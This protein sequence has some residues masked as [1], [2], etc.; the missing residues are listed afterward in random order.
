MDQSRSPQELLADLA[1]QQD[2]VCLDHALRRKSIKMNGLTATEVD[3]AAD[4]RRE[5]RDRCLQ[6]RGRDV[7]YGMSVVEDPVVSTDLEEGGECNASGHMH[8]KAPT[9]NTDEVSSS[10]GG[11]S[12]EEEYRG[13][14]RRK[15]FDLNDLLNKSEEAGWI[16]KAPADVEDSLKQWMSDA[17]W[18]H[19]EADE[20]VNKP[21]DFASQ[22]VTDFNN[23][24]TALPRISGSS[25]SP[26]QDEQST[27]P[28]QP[29]PPAIPLH[30]HQQARLDHFLD[31]CIW[32]VDDMIA[33]AEFAL[34]SRPT[35]EEVEMYIEPLDADGDD[36]PAEE[37]D[38]AL[39]QDAL[40]RDIDGLL[41]GGC[42]LGLG[43]SEGVQ[44]AART[45]VL[46]KM[47]RTSSSRIPK[48]SGLSVSKPVRRSEIP[49]LS[50]TRSLR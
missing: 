13:T 5:D 48:L 50:A 20:C 30:S 36:V 24:I 1:I 44:P 19:R 41:G 47:T 31:R 38:P 16:P 14:K 4:L 17:N 45:V 8:S 42:G 28:V 26:I 2:D 40:M 34:A 25:Q 29:K 7:P 3:G 32:R 11:G 23:P 37:F 33:E 18:P 46:T 10:D 22:G 39:A 35:R 43:L 15:R 27:P 12:Y 6:S 49:V 9:L 21:C